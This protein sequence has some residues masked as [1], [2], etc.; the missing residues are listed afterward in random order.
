M[1]YDFAI[2]LDSFS[3]PTTIHDREPLNGSKKLK[4]IVCSTN[5]GL[6]FEL[7]KL[8][9]LDV[10]L[11]YL[12]LSHCCASE[13]YLNPHEHIYCRNCETAYPHEVA[14]YRGY[15]RAG[16]GN[17][18]LIHEWVENFLD[19]FTTVIISNEINARLDDLGIMLGTFEYFDIYNNV[20]L[21]ER[22]ARELSGALEETRRC[23]YI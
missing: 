3:L 19:P 8:P 21:L 11:Q 4:R 15:R 23:S 14:L 12:L 16:R 13:I 17:R 20:T 5:F 9:G 1:T 6:N 18:Q 22:T 7:K 2:A 10:R